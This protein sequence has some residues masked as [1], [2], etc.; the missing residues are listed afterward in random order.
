MERMTFLAE[1]QEL[2]GKL[3]VKLKL[4]RHVSPLKR[5]QIALAPPQ[6]HGRSRKMQELERTK[7]T[8]LNLRKSRWDSPIL[9]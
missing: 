9:N 4:Q 7:R 6:R 3:M 1:M 5:S 2:P 8:Y